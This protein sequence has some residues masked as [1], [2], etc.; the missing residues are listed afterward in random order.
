MPALVIIT[1]RHNYLLNTT[2]Y[3]SVD[4]ALHSQSTNWQY[5]NAEHAVFRLLLVNYWS[6]LFTIKVET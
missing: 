6:I 4:T 2:N 1:S 5:L 3:S